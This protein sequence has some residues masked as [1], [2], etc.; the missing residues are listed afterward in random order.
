MPSP[1]PELCRRS[2]GA[3]PFVGV[4]WQQELLPCLA[5]EAGLQLSV[6]RLDLVVQ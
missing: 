6:E 5:Q 2:T 4:D 1:K 3:D